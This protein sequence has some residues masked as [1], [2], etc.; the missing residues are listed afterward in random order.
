MVRNEEKGRYTITSCSSTEAS[1]A[2]A[3]N[4]FIPTSRFTP[5]P[6][7]IVAT[8]CISA[9]QYSVYIAYKCAYK[10]AYSIPGTHVYHAL[11]YVYI[12]N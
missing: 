12:G 1:N 7:F 3:P 10:Y 2:I 8:I 6:F 5:S 4:L 11:L 9:H